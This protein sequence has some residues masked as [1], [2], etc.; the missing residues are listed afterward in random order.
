VSK[1]IVTAGGS[2]L[3][4]SGSDDPRMA[5]AQKVNRESPAE[6]RGI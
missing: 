1:F 2:N 4:S 3:A 5:W 6:Y